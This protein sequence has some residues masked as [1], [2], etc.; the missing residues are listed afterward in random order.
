M[1]KASVLL[2][3]LLLLCFTGNS[4][5]I[6]EFDSY[7]SEDFI[8]KCFDVPKIRPLNGGTVFNTTYEGD[9]SVEM[10]GAFE[11]ACKIWEE[12]LPPSIPIKIKAS[13][14]TIT[15]TTSNPISKVRVR[16]YDIQL[17]ELYGR[18]SLLSQLRG[19]LVKGADCGNTPQF[20]DNYQDLSFLDEYDIELTYNQN[21]LDEVSFSL[22]STPVDKY[23]FVSV[24]IRDLAKGLGVYV[25]LRANVN[26][27]TLY[28]TKQ[29]NCFEWHLRR[30]LGIDD[31]P[32]LAYQ[33]ATQ[34]VFSMG[35]GSS[36]LDFY[37]PQ[38]WQQGI[39]LNTFVTDSLSPQIA[40][41]LAYDFGKGSVCRD[42]SKVNPGNNFFENILGWKTSIV[43]GS[44]SP[45]TTNI[46]STDDVIQIG[47][48]IPLPTTT[49]SMQVSIAL[50]ETERMSKASRSSIDDPV[51]PFTLFYNTE[52]RDVGVLVSV[53][54]KDGTWDNVY[55]FF[56]NSPTISQRITYDN[57][58]F[59]FSSDEYARTSD[60]YLRCRI[61]HGYRILTGSMPTLYYNTRYYA[62]DCLP[63]TLEMQYQGVVQN[64]AT[65]T[66]HDEYLRDVKIGL[67]NLEGAKRVVVE[68]L[69][70]G[71]EMPT[72]LEISDFKKGYFIA[73][74]D[75]EF[76][77]TFTAYSINDN[78]TKTSVPL[79]I[80]A[81]EPPILN[82]SV[83]TTNESIVI[84]QQESKRESQL[85][86]YEIVPLD[87]YNTA[88]SLTGRVAT[89]EDIDIRELNPGIYSL[90]YYTNPNDKHSYKFV[91]SYK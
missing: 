16:A 50:E 60:G 71:D 66:L 6:D 40:Q 3:L 74:V 49:N 32:G 83:R 81:I 62:M 57:L 53:L 29:P 22:Y 41:I 90:V 17:E 43:T 78:G 42:V 19:V 64:I 65:R 48:N 44:S 14:G 72:I 13:I 9:W 1:K 37:A 59:H 2:G 36:S 4:Q 34:G 8:E 45:S 47:D 76:D 11:Y 82:Y 54:K 26:N 23:D 67:K 75:K 18:L 24:V 63:Q 55:S 15:G 31:N 69:I 39:S 12:I 87:K 20:E 51:E 58:T 28:Y 79:Y 70:D 30:S 21:R 46:G 91:K 61:T 84:K 38:I 73:T 77:T 52:G 5:S 27:Q 89:S 68:Q 56:L 25:D 86:Y 35:F 80:T 33:K 7:V 88:K 10:K 85:I